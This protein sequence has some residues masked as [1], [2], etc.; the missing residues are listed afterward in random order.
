MPKHDVDYSCTV[1]YKITCKDTNIPDKYVGHT[2]DFVK[3]KYAHK[4]SSHNETSANYHLKLYKFIRD[5]GGWDNWKMEMIQFYDCENQH[6]ARV[7]EQEHYIELKATLNSIEPLRP[8]VVLDKIDTCDYMCVNKNTFDKH[9]ASHKCVTIEPVVENSPI[10]STVD[11]Y[12]C[13]KC[14]FSCC[15]KQHYKQHCSSNKHKRLVDT[16]S[17][18][19]GAARCA[20]PSISK[21]EYSCSWCGH[22]YVDRTGLWKHIKKCN[23]NTHTTTTSNVQY[24]DIQQLLADNKE[25]RSFMLEQANENKMLHIEHKHEIVEMVNRLVEQASEHNKDASA[26]FHKMMEMVDDARHQP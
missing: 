17:A 10:S 18:K 23:V 5:N 12:A 8:T 21:R 25:L 14:D 15:K 7:K 11:K 6:D 19:P 20:T 24:A 26:I 22:Q 2:T 3:R 1:I 13:E 9:V 16:T 4:R